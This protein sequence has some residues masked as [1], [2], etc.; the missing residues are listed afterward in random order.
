MSETPT[1]RPRVAV[2]G[3]GISGLAAAHRLGTERPD[4]EVVLLEASDHIGGKLLRTRVGGAVIDVGA[5]SVLARR[6]EAVELATAL[7]LADDTIN[8]TAGTA[9]IRGRGVNR[10]LPAGTLLGI[11]TDLSSLRESG[12]LT[13]ET[14]AHIAAEPALGPYAPLGGDV[15]VGDLVAARFGVEVVDRLVDPL[16]GGV[17][18]GH[19]HAISVQAALPAL[20][21]RLIDH[22]ESLLSAARAVVGAGAR[23]PS[24]DTP[25]APVFA[26]YRGGLARLPE[27]LAAS[28]RFEVRTSATV[29]ELARD[30]EGFI[31]TVGSAADSE[32]LHADA[33]I[34]AAPANKA[35]KL[36]RSAAPVAALELS[37]IE[38][39]SVAIVTLA[40]AGTE[41]GLPDGSG[42]LV[43]A[44]EGYDIKAM[45]F[46]SQKWPGVGADAGVTLMRASLGRAGEEWVLQR[47]DHELVEL[48]LR[49]LKVL[50]DLH[51]APID[52]HVQRWGGGLPQYVVG[53]VSRVSRV[54]EAVAQVPG[55]ALC[56]AT[57]DGVGIPACIASANIAAD[58]VSGY[59][60]AKAE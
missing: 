42:V 51:T 53:H 48:V 38:F 46:S 23:E 5:E 54:R 25:P 29:R 22:G 35:S 39:A 18:A 17:Y 58:R 55:L 44:V 6:P 56:G 1:R 16:L 19:A 9:L 15:S 28:G 3:G 60:R 45:T 4:L 20:A 36:L 26:S 34:I 47:E 59:L 50:I 41:V 10:P 13:D 31:L 2:V 11:P 40:F 24:D 37:E 27:L 43:P 30:T 32:L 21:Y 33:V 57:F 7:G 8:P 12:L 49:E 14:L 52:T